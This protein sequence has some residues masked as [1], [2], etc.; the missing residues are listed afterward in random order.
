[1]GKLVHT[2]VL[3]ISV[4]IFVSLIGIGYAYWNN[5]ISISTTIDTGEIEL[6]ILSIEP[7]LE[8]SDF[9]VTNFEI[10]I[11][12]EE[13]VET[14]V[15]KATVPSGSGEALDVILSVVNTGS[16]PVFIDENM[17]EPEQVGKTLIHVNNGTNNIDYSYASWVKSLI[18]EA[19]I[20]ELVPLI[21]TEVTSV[22]AV[23]L[24]LP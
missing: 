18:I 9:E 20:N 2:R 23:T 22:D 17:I 19:E 16:V 3:L 10:M 12:D 8:T 24:I 1:M 5:S 6:S 11:S 13:V 21:N 15:L 7:V 4:I 14:A